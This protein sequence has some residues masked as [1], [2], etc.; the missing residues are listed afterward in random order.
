MK[1]AF[2]FN[3]NSGKGKILKKLD[4][5]LSSLKQ[6]F[7][8]VESI[9]T[10]S[11]ED[12]L[13]QVKK[14]CQ[15]FDV[16][17]FSGGDGTVNDVVNVVKQNN[18]NIT[19]GYIPSGTCNDFARSVGISKN[20]KKAVK[21]ICSG[22]AKPFDGFLMNNRFG[23]YVC[24]S[25]IFTSASYDTNQKSKRAFGKL[26]YYFH[27]AKEAFKAESLDIT[28]SFDGGSAKTHNSVL[29]LLV[30][31]SSVAGWRFN[32]GANLH[33]GK[34][35]FVSIETLKPNKKIGFKALM[36]VVRMFLFGVKSIKKNKRVK[37]QQFET[38]KI[39]MKANSI[40]NVDGENAGTG[41]INLKV[42]KNMINLIVD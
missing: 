8:V 15:N 17:V 1:C 36:V 35:D 32:K 31:S 34:M 7:N 11:K 26:G 30:N 29:F 33:D 3:P 10:K 22:L 20:I 38:A 9:K 40:I 28:Y 37:F 24:T 41:E 23:V 12:F 2:L 42:C 5:I 27:S 4:F 39:Q 16:L 14:A 13:N 6:K 19:L 18:F 25:G 21:T